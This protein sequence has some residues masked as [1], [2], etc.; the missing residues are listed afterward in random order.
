[1]TQKTHIQKLKL[2]DF[3]N[4]AQANLP[5]SDRHV[6]LTGENGSGKTNLMEA[7]SLLSPGRGL[8]RAVLADIS[9][10][11]APQG[12]SVFA[13][14]EG[15]AGDV[16]IGTG[17]EGG[18]DGN[19][20]RRL[21]IN[22]ASAKSVDELTDHLRVLWLTP[23]MDGLFTGA[24]AD[25]RRFLDRLVLSLDPA[26]GRRASDFERAMRSRN[27]L[28]ADGRFD[29]TWLAGIEQ[30]MAALGVAM[31]M[32]RREMLGLLAGLIAD[33]LTTSR[34]P[35]ASLTL[36]G[37]LD[38]DAQRPAYELEDLYIGMLAAG[39]YRDAAAGRTLDGPH[40]AD[41]VIR[42]VEKNMEAERCSTGEQKALLI[43]LILAH[44]RLVATMTGFA[45][46]LL[47]D[48]IAAHLDEGRRAAL[49]DRI[50]ALGGQSFMT[51][52]DK[53][54]F[55]ALGTRAQFISVHHGKLEI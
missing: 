22:G 45:P 51:G 54:M 30:Q 49:F 11:D 44:A 17:T 32:A 4:Y 12:F 3:R 14:L 31:T 9:R 26:H 42:H 41:L 23:A 50:D 38:D 35:S 39:R 53:S 29:P 8:R 55:E 18:E 20:V 37:F 1:M 19:P 24:S 33:D 15:M 13:A 2:T 25:R 43:G 34:F 10:I 48:E 52:T 36:T 21:R 46:I 47:L 5:L 40:R 6:V 16:E 28:L 7:V 27:K